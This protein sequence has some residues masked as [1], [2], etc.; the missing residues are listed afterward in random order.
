MQAGSWRVWIWPR[1]FAADVLC[2]AH[3]DLR[4]VGTPHISSPRECD[5]VHSSAKLRGP[6]LML[7]ESDDACV[8]LPTDARTNISPKLHC[9]ELSLSD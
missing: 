3:V 2:K 6:G 4:R 9:G 7:P 5:F 1:D 8:V